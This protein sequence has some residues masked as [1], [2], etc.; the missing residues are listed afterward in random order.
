VLLCSA[1]LCC[2]GANIK[3][4]MAGWQ[5]VCHKNLIIN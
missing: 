3:G 1:A 5:V 4:R 2:E